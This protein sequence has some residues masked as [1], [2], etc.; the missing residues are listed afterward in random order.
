LREDIRLELSHILLREGYLTRQ[1]TKLN[2]VVID[3]SNRSYTRTCQ[4]LGRG[5]AQPTRSDNQYATLFQPSL[6]L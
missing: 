4:I 2:A 6:S 5:S 3:E 1:V